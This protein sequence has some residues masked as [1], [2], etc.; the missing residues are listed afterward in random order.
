MAA[1]ALLTQRK[2]LVY[3]VLGLGVIGAALGAMAW[4]GV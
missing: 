3:G 1:I 2:W 4:M